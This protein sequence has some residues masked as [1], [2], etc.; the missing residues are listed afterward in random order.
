MITDFNIYSS[1][2]AEQQFIDWTAGCKSDP[3]DIFSWDSEKLDLSQ[4]EGSQIETEIVDVERK[5]VCLDTSKPVTK[6]KPLRIL[7]EIEQVSTDSEKKSSS[8]L[9]SHLEYVGD[10]SAHTFREA[11]GRCMRLTG[12]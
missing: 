6:K 9:G 8:F 4:E 3:G 11:M 12:N 5:H 7:P 2:F 1:F 10:P